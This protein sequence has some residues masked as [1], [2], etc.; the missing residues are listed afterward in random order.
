M[1]DLWGLGFPSITKGFFCHKLKFL[2]RQLVFCVL[3]FWG[4]KRFRI[5]FFYLF[6]T[7][8]FRLKFGSKRAFGFFFG[9]CCFILI[10]N[11]Y[12]FRLKVEILLRVKICIK[13]LLG[14]RNVIHFWAVFPKNRRFLFNLTQNKALL[15]NNGGLKN[16]QRR[17]NINHLGIRSLIIRKRLVIH[18][19]FMKFGCL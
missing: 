19:M 9:S 14:F 18:K 1:L 8:Q 11:D 16:L 3:K 10:G 17:L 6:Y 7:F 13:I 2:G 15:L 4:F 5:L 12:W